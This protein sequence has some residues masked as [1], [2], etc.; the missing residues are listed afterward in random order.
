MR[1]S[2]AFIFTKKIQN[3]QLTVPSFELSLKAGLIHQ[4]SAGSYD[5]L[6]LGNRVIQKI[7]NIVREEMN[8]S[9]ALEIS[10]PIVQPGELW[11][12]SGRWNAYGKEM[13]KFKNRN[14]AD[15]C[16]APTHEEVAVDLA[17][18]FV[19]SYKQFPFNLYQIGRKFRDEMRPKNGLLRSR[20][21]IMKDAYSFDLDD[22]GLDIS[23]KKMREAYLEITKRM[24]LNVIP[25]SADPGEI[26]GSGSEEFMA[27]TDKGDDRFVIVNNSGIKLENLNE[28]IGLSQ[29]YSGI[30][31]GHIFKLGTKY[32]EQMG[33][34]YKNYQGI[35]V[36]PSMGCYGIGITRLV[37]AIIEQHH[38]EKGIKWPK[39][40]APF[41]LEIIPL[42]KSSNIIEAAN[43]FYNLF[44]DKNI[45]VLVDDRDI[46]AGAKLKDSDLIGVPIKLILG[47]KNY[48]NNQIE[49]Q[50][51]QTNQKNIVPVNKAFEVYDFYKSSLI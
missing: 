50:N 19:Q 14:D 31:I 24:A 51:R 6:P 42:S 23:Y 3:E 43:Y 4:V 8:S 13:V 17:K 10:M 34:K 41:D 11:K 48:S 16:L 38:D 22:S 28:D 25:V 37:S 46:S 32:S 1:F 44:K 45:E 5:F 12:Q 9:G 29:I 49:Y 33:F 7:E 40:V 39:E 15:F 47:D 36:A 20:E 27:I 26:G 21:F 2:Q 35:D 18:S 30:E